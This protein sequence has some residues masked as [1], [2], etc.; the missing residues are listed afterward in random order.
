MGVGRF[1]FRM[2]GKVI[3][4]PVYRKIAAFHE[5]TK[6]PATVQKALLERIIQ[7]QAGTAF[8]R[9]HGFSSIRTIDDYRRQVA[10]NPYENL[11]P[12]I[13]RM[14]KGEVNALVA[15]PA[16]L[17]FAL[18]SGTTAARKHIPI[19]QS[20]LDDYRHGWNIWGLTG[21]K[22]HPAIKLRP[23]MQLV[24]DPEE[25]RT[26]AGIPCGNLSGFTAQVQ[27]RIIRFL[28]SVPAI[29]GKIKD[30]QA[31]YY[32]ALRFSVPRRVGMLSTANPSTLVALAR[33][34]DAEKENLIR[35]IRDGTLNPKLDLPAEARAAL[36]SKAKK[37]DPACAQKLE[38]AIRRDGALLPSAVWPA[39]TILLGCWTGGSVGPYLRQLPRYYANTPVRDIG[40]LA[41]EG[42]FTIPIEDNN[43]AGVLDI[44]SHYFEF[45]PE[46]EIDSP[47]PTVLAA[48]EVREGGSYFILPT[49]R[50]GLYRY[51]ISDLV[52]VAGFHHKTPLIEFLGKGNRFANLTG[53]KLSEHHVTRAIDQSAR[54]A[55]QPISAYSMAPCWDDAQPYYGLFIEDQDT[56]N[57]ERLKDFL[58]DLDRALGEQNIEYAA[59]RDSGRLGPVRV[60]VL[61]PGTWQRWDRERLAQSGGSPEQ[62]KHPCL[63]GDLNFRQSM[64]VLREIAA[65]EPAS[66]LVG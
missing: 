15:D 44:A 29:S 2:V 43:P 46:S 3:A 1:L 58:E 64:P 16:V 19:T 10:I 55:G 12:Y 20:Y 7:T 62:Y 41:S 53:E 13:H 30:S 36:T 50:A 39:D 52:R 49:T 66:V 31:R 21:M 22:A 59:K 5:L 11:A 28:Y 33:V 61:P 18:T 45:I 65:G 23:V 37:K 25:Y 26:E 51:H 17:M 8:G 54:K 4:R 57:A 48:H 27:K 9:D 47:K 32:V 35:D 34:M 40:L 14:M 63:I 56:A 42:R 24:G 60:E 38:E 6:D